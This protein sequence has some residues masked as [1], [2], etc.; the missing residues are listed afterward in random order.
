MGSSY[1]KERR[2]PA[3]GVLM[4][5][6]VLGQAWRE[7]KSGDVEVRDGDRCHAIRL[8]EGNISE[9]IWNRRECLSADTKTIKVEQHVE[10]LFTLP[11]PHVL[12]FPVPILKR[13]LGSINP[14]KLV[15]N[16]IF[17]RQE[18]FKPTAL[19]E[20]IPVNTLKIDL[21]KEAVIRNLPLRADEIAFLKRLHRPTPIAMILWKRGLKPDH[22]SALLVA[23]NLLGLFDGEWEPGDLPRFTPAT[24]I[25]RR[26]TGACSDYELLGVDPDA[27]REEIDRAFRKLSM[28]LHPDRLLKL[29]EKDVALA[30]EAFLGASSAYDRLK[31]SRRSRPVTQGRTSIAEVTLNEPPVA[32]WSPLLGEARVSS[33]RGETQRA[34]AFAL[35]ALALSPPGDIRKELLGILKRAA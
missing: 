34:K 22:A 33:A 20:R 2:D 19:I 23:L 14:D 3:S 26:L 27:P 30:K 1:R 32:S 31:R 18:L 8:V 17:K 10:R 7:R 25:R 5:G 29:P 9:I 35:K 15:I 13:G 11:R 21:E 6:S 12:F 28:A 24:Q 16:G 4:L